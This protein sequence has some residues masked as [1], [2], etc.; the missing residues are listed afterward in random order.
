V[1]RVS[2]FTVQNSAGSAMLHLNV[3]TGE[4]AFSKGRFIPE[5]GAGLIFV[6]KSRELYHRNPIVE[7]E[8]AYSALL[9]VGLRG[10]SGVSFSIDEVRSVVRQLRM[11]QAGDPGASFIMQKGLYLHRDKKQVI[12]EN[13]V[14]VIILLLTGETQKEFQDNI[15]RLG[16]ELARVFDQEEVLVEFQDRGVH[17]KVF[18]AKP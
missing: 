16:E 1:G 9:I 13:S 12:E 7:Y 10:N 5:R 3:D 17:E 14:R 2:R 18:G 15:F 11:E 6:G 8:K 4:F